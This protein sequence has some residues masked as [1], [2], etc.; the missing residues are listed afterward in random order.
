[1]RRLAKSGWKR[2]SAALILLVWV[3][4]LF[5]CS[6]DCL[7]APCH[8]HS[9]RSQDH[10]ADSHS[11]TRSIEHGDHDSHAPAQAPDSNEFC[12]SLDSMLMPTSQGASLT[13]Q[14]PLAWVLSTPIL[15]GKLPLLDFELL[16]AR[17]T[18]RRDWVFTHEV[19]TASANRSHAPP[20]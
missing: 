2:A 14:L 4:A 9:E 13:P 19:C 20:V 12:R 15:T 6:A 16:S 5:F 8:S 3:G 10:H 17:Q 11:A 18:Q 7:W 1:M